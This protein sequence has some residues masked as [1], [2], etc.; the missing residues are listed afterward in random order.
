G[1]KGLTF[2]TP[3]E[4]EVICQDLSFS[5]AKGE[6]VLITGPSGCGK[7]SLLRAVAGLWT[8]GKGTIQRPVDT[9]VMFVPQ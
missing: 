7:S 6:S 4:K 8:T 5:V 1:S 2:H 9:Q 3:D